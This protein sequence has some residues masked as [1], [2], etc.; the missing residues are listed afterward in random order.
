M[1]MAKS[2][3]STVVKISRQIEGDAERSRRAQAR[4][5]ATAIREAEKARKQLERKRGLALRA[6]I[7]DQKRLEREAKAAHV[8]AMEA[9]VEVQ[10]AEL[11]DIYE[12]LSSLLA[13]TLD[14]DDYVDQYIFAM[15]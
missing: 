10:N 4:E 11:A 14:V 7:A 8:T 1:E 2:I 12:D 13:T 6:G 15:L 5:H 9:D 3:L